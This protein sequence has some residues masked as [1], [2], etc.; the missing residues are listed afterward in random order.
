MWPRFRKELRILHERI[1]QAEADF[2]SFVI[3]QQKAHQVC[4]QD[5]EAIAHELPVGQTICIKGL[6]IFD[7]IVKSS[8]VLVQI[9]P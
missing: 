1:D 8:P 7:N 5:A 9:L 2:D 4:D 3:I 6:K